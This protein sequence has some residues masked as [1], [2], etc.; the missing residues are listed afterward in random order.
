MKSTLGRFFESISFLMRLMR[1]MQEASKKSPNKPKTW[2]FE[3]WCLNM[4]S[5]VDVV[6][7]AAARFPELSALLSGQDGEPI[8]TGLPTRHLRRRANAHARRHRSRPRKAQASR[9]GN[10]E[11]PESRK[12]RRAP[13]ALLDAHDSHLPDEGSGAAGEASRV[14]RWLETHIWNAKRMHN[15]DQVTTSF[16]ETNPCFPHTPSPAAA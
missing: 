14:S 16:P 5:L 4:E 9:E 13:R 8:G 7:L 15:H 1:T 6:G 11:E 10:T 2:I 3:L 12:R